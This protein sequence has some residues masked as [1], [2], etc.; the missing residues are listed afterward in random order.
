M[1]LKNLADKPNILLIVTD[2]EREVMHWP[3]GWAEDNLPARKRLMAN[4]LTF[5]NA[6]C[7][8]AACTP[9]RATLMT[10]LYPAQ[11]GLKNL[12]FCDN[13]NDKTQRRTPQLSPD[14]PN[15]ATVMA[16]A[17]YHVVLKG[18]FHLSRPV[19]WNTEEQRHYWSD[20]DVSL[21]QNATASMSGIHRI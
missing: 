17:G 11:H 3:E 20:A 21:S 12:L 16:E 15:I 5:G 14:I 18:K 8:T 6:H 4:G 2:Q 19:C 1:T 13:P 7:N 10:G 9:S